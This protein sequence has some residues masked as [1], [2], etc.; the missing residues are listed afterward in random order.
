MGGP[1]SRVCCFRVQP[2]GGSRAESE[3]GRCRAAGALTESAIKALGRRSELGRCF[4]GQAAARLGVGS[5]GGGER[6]GGWPLSGWP[7][8]VSVAVRLRS[9]SGLR[10]MLAGGAVRSSPR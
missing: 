8:T 2:C 7:T 4:D 9:C 5:L 10:P 1:Y 3:C 6:A